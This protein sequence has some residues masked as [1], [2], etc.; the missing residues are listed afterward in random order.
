ML[1]GRERD[2]ARGVEDRDQPALE[3][4]HREEAGY[5]ADHEAG[6]RHRLLPVR[7]CSGPARRDQTGEGSPRRHVAI[8]VPA[9]HVERRARPYP[10]IGRVSGGG[11]AAWLDR[12]Q[13]YL[14]HRSRQQCRAFRGQAV[15]ACRILIAQLARRRV[16]RPSVSRHPGRDPPR[17]PSTAS[18]RRTPARRTLSGT[19]GASPRWSRSRARLRRHPALARPGNID[20]ARPGDGLFGACLF[21]GMPVSSSRLE[22]VPQGGPLLGGQTRDCRLTSIRTTP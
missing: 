17:A 8:A 18:P 1:P 5:E 6:W 11:R 4:Q 12:E 7:P 20:P 22:A 3:G 10:R 19:G 9:G 2:G 13:P 21:L 15:G 16:A 14:G